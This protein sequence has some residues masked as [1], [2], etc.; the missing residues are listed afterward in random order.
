[1]S[2]RNPEAP[3]FGPQDHWITPGLYFF[4][5]ADWEQQEKSSHRWKVCVIVIIILLRVKVTQVIPTPEL[6]FLQ[7]RHLWH[8]YFLFWMVNFSEFFFSVSVASRHKSFTKVSSSQFCSKPD[9]YI[10][11]GSA[12][13]N[14]DPKQLR[15]SENGHSVQRL[16]VTGAEF[17]PSRFFA[18]SQTI[19]PNLFLL[20]K[21]PKHFPDFLMQQTRVIRWLS[22]QI[23]QNHIGKNKAMCDTQ[24]HFKQNDTF[25]FGSDIQYFL[26]MLFSFSP[27]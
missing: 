20:L 15:F 5:C 27:C 2:F 18:Q 9:L 19:Y 22:F 24:S 13:W 11:P 26:P 12:S 4:N 1:M 23:C 14:Q 10:N 21:T 3:V 6:W 16:L 25:T 7:L 17:H 8:S